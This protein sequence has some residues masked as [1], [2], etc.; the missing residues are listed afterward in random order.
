LP[1]SL[2]VPLLDDLAPDG[3]FYGGHYIV[4]F[5][6]D[7]LWYETSLTIAALALKQGMKTQ[8]HVFQHFPSEAVEAISRLGVDAKKLKEEGL[9][10][11]WDGYTRTVDYE[12]AMRDKHGVELDKWKS[13]HEKP[14]DLEKSSANV[15]KEFKAG[16]SEQDKRWLHLDDN[17]G[18]MLQYV[19]EE[20]F[21][22]MWRTVGLPYYIRPV[23]C[24]HFL[25]Y[26]KGVASDAFYT[27][28]EAL[29]DGIID[30]KAQEEGGRI[31]NYLRVRML[32]GKRFDSSWHRLLLGSDG[33]VRLVGA[34][35]QAE[36]RRLAAIMFTDIVG[37]T[38]LSQRNESLALSVLDQQRELV[39]PVFD[40]HGGK[41]VK[42]IGDAFLVDFPSAL[43]AVKCAY[44]IQ[45]TT[46]EFNNSLPEERMVR[47][48]IGVHLGDVVESQGDI[49]GDAVNIASRIESLADS[50]GVCL[51]RQVYDQVQNKF[52]L[53]LRSLGAKSLK[54]L[55]G[56]LEVFKMVMPW[57]ESTIEEAV[58]LDSHR[59]A[60][61]P[62]KNMSPD[63]N[64]EYFADGMTEE[65]ITALS[66]VRELTV[67][68]RTSIMQYKASPKRVAAIAKE[69]KTGTV[70]EGSVRKAANKVRITVQM[71]DATTEGHLW[72]QNYDRQLDDIFAIQS[73]IAE[74]VAD[75][76]KV[77]LV[78]STRS[79]L[80]KRPTENTEAYM[81][82][83][84]GRYYWNERTEPSVEKGIA[85]LQKAVQ[86]DPNLAVA[87]SD[88]ADAHLIMADYGN[89]PIS[90]AQA[91]AR[92][93]VTRALE[94]EPSLS[95]PHAALG[96]IHGRNF[97]WAD[98]EDEYKLAIRLNPNNATAH[99]WYAR[100]LSLMGKENAM[101]EW[102]KAK[103]LDP[104]S[105][106]IGAAFGYR[107]VWSGRREEGL[108]MLRTVVEMNDAF[109]P[110][111]RNL[112]L[113]YVVAG[114]NADAAA[115]ARKIMDLNPVPSSK[116]IAACAY[117]MAGFKEEATTILKK[118]LEDSEASYIDPG[119]IASIYASLGD[120]SNAIEWLERAVNEKSAWV[121]YTQVYPMFSSFRDNPRFRE[122]SRKIGLE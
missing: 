15:K 38:A 21:V 6:P 63:P 24:P 60:V 118:L 3:F 121:T 67:I 43:S 83:L 77:K 104:L 64:D 47:L 42:S 59:V 31:E 112:A 8:Y 7:S 11:I 17:T 18:I 4:E 57:E 20:E 40:K 55:R 53:P 19:D 92:E 86:L 80:E 108:Q 95:Q 56:P 76:L 1:E 10:Q 14:F 5:D 82:Y 35:P 45:K 94:I 71:V 106:I 39:R 46:R 119:S 107:L 103:E 74:K 96:N 102:K 27:K 87:Y 100:E 13:T 91:K 48:R 54:S 81:L 69:L 12:A 62:L 98:A 52:D 58:E 111:H 99:H 25:A 88:L 30:V 26:V 33:Q 70:I 44:E 16:Y 36:K 22:D 50:G 32:R 72:A 66:G 65:L 34:T 120:E 29:C 73:E 28:Y 110:G 115:E 78:Y 114:M 101:Q 51:T 109:I 2:K 97:R 41:E 9:L 68:A 84:K 37:F 79:R 113:A 90:E 117:A 89:M 93:Y 116:A 61:L 23:E 105:L 49:S 75:A 122:I 85:Y